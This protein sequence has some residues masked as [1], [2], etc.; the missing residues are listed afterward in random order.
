MKTKKFTKFK[1]KYIQ[2]KQKYN[3]TYNV[4]GKK[5]TT[6]KYNSYSFSVEVEGCIII[7]KSFNLW[8]LKDLQIFAC[9]EKNL[10]FLANCRVCV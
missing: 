1:K 10:L 3:S 5:K 8:F 4:E 9:P 6:T 7:I 2:F